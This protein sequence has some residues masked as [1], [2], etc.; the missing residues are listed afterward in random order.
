MESYHKLTSESKFFEKLSRVPSVAF[1]TAP[2]H[3]QGKILNN[4]YGGA[5]YVR[6]ASSWDCGYTDRVPRFTYK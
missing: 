5:R 4:T 1:L 3:Q 6:S 2:V